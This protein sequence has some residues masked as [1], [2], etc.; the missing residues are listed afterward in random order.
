VDTEQSRPPVSFG[1][2]KRLT[3]KTMKSHRHSSEEIERLNKHP[4][5][6]RCFPRAIKYTYEFK[7][8]ALELFNQGVTSKEIWRRSGFDLSTWRKT[9]TKDCLKEWRLVVKKK[10]FEGLNKDDKQGR[11]VEKEPSDAKKIK[12]LELQIK[13]LKAENDFL[14]K[15]RAKRAESN[16][17]QNKNVK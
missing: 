10:G 4:C 13:Y 3:K 7:K 8:R 12:R 9:Y 15:L 2:I 1:R 17:S 5:V 11:S 6:V 16:S 14:A